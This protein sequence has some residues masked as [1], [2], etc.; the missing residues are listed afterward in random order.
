MSVSTATPHDTAPNNA[1]GGALS[2]HRQVIEDHVEIVRRRQTVMDWVEALGYSLIGIMATASL[3][4]LVDRLVFFGVTP[5]LLIASAGVLGVIIG[6]VYVLMNRR[7]LV[8][9]A[10]DIDRVMGLN[11]RTSAALSITS[12]Q[13]PAEMAL[14]SD[15]RSK[16]TACDLHEAFPY[17]FKGPFMWLPLA[18]GITALIGAYMPYYDALGRRKAYKDHQANVKKLKAKAIQLE[19]R[20]EALKRLAE[21]IDRPEMSNVVKDLQSLV[22]DLKRGE[23]TQKEA[24]RAMNKLSDKLRN[25]QKAALD[26]FKPGQKRKLKSSAASKLQ[27]ALSQG[28]LRKAR[29]NVDQMRRKL[30]QGKASNSELKSLSESLKQLSKDISK[31]SKFSKALD[32]ASEDLKAGQMAEAEKALK[33]AQHMLK[34]TENIKEQMQ[35]MKDM[36]ELAKDPNIDDLSEDNQNPLGKDGELDPEAEK[37][38]NWKP[39]PGQNGQNGQNGQPGQNGQN[40]NKN[41]QQPGKN[42]QQPGKNGQQPGKNGQQPGKNGQQPGQNGQQP[43][44]NGQQPG[45]NGQ[46]PGKN[47]QQP[48]QNGQQPG[49][50]QPGQGQPGQGQPGQGQPGQNGQPGQGQPGQNGGPNGQGGGKMPYEDKDAKYKNERIKGRISKMHVAG[51]FLFKGRQIKGEAKEAFK[52][53]VEVAKKRETEAIRKAP[54]PKGYKTYVRDYFEGI[55]PKGR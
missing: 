2:N 48:G 45:Q 29:E 44:K 24:M 22:D 35:L 32:K 12:P 49:Q 30:Q 36:L 46:Q 28:N 34:D 18:F 23:L 7:E 42:G 25:A 9:T 55:T 51:A 13:R 47:G 26:R 52:K 3:I 38:D 27:K 6:T 10:I 41:G 54:I 50:G 14:L 33:E 53:A 19:K 43:G 21:R 11:E 17:D 20:A 39:Q 1:M 5:A 15:A 4:L 37:T 40:G 31:N 16:I 8:D